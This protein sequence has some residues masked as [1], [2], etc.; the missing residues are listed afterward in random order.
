[1]NGK[2]VRWYDATVHPGV[3]V[4]HY[5]TSAIE[6]IKAR[7]VNGN[8][9][10][11]EL[12]EHINRLFNSMQTGFYV[13][14]SNIP[15]TREQMIQGVID[16]VVA[17]KLDEAYIRPVLYLDNI[18]WKPGNPAATP[19]TEGNYMGFMLDGSKIPVKAFIIVVPFRYIGTNV[20]AKVVDTT[21]GASSSMPPSAKVGTNY[22]S[23]IR[24]TTEAKI[25]GFDDAVQLEPNRTYVAEAPGANIFIY[26][27]RY[28]ITPSQGNILPGFTRKSVMELANDLG[29]RVVERPITKDEM[30]NVAVEAFFS[31]TAAGIADIRQIDK[32]TLKRDL[33]LQMQNLFEKYARGEHDLSHGRLTHYR[34]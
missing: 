18:G 9:A 34:V 33:S 19:P 10:V 17:N 8:S 31:G 6:G 11:L 7:R 21:R 24:G 5:S 4:I 20:R 2:L 22:G 12:P 27:G 25:A 23:S 1:M 29:V 32:K 30:M 14:D 26:D 28:L 16:T 15:V 3:H 13:P